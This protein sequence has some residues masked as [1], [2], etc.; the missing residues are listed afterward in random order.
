M[1]SHP[2]LAV[3]L[4]W[5]VTLL[6]VAVAISLTIGNS[7]IN[8]ESKYVDSSKLQAVFLNG[9]QVYFGNILDLNDKFVRIGNIY[10]L[11]VNQQVQPNQSNNSSSNSD[12]TLV[13]L[14][15]ELHGPQDEM[16]V[17]RDQVVFWEN[18]KSDGQVTKA[19]EQFVKANPNGQKCTTASN[20]N[21][22]TSNKQ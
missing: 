18:L 19:V 5:S 12:V 6:I 7:T 13:K 15:C 3:T 16:L 1:S 10:Y 4:L 22:T 9:G 11:R 21:N 14:G 8:R 20:S 17:N 2:K